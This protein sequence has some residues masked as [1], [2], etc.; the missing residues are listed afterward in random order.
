[1]VEIASCDVDLQINLI[2]ESD[3][4][5]EELNNIPVIK[6]FFL[7]LCFLCRNNKYKI[8]GTNEFSS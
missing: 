8:F 1:M 3:F 4:K 5:Y 2:D 7:S 6:N